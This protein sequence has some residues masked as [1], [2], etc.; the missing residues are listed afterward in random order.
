VAWA[1]TPGHDAYWSYRDAFFALLPP[2]GGAVLEVGCGEG[3]VLRDLRGRGY[4]VVGLDASPTLLEA[5]Q[6]LDAEGRY[7]LG[8]AEEL[9]FDA[10]SFD[11]VVAYNVLMDVDDM[12]RAVAEIARVLRPG[13]HLCAC[14]T[15]PMNDVGGFAEDGTFVIRGSY[16]KEGWISVS[17]ERDGLDMLFDGRTYPLESY[18]RALEEGG[19]LLE[20]LREPAAPA[21]S[22]DGDRWSRIPL[23]LLFRAVS[24]P[25]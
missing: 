23:F 10:G 20:A 19:F 24:A 6:S 15:H 7:L 14:V 13:G 16:L 18:A 5:A 12:P 9:P 1:R 11:L 25:G 22:P 2:P 17:V 3:R 8:R 4:D 21:D